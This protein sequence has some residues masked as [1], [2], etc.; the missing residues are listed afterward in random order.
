MYDMINVE[1]A[2]SSKDDCSS[3]ARFKSGYR[4]ATPEIVIRKFIVRDTRVSLSIN[5][6]VVT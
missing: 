1:C 4:T 3:D 6:F 5:K 2:E